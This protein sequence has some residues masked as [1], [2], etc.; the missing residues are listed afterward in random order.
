MK[1]LTHCLC[2]QLSSSSNEQYDL[3]IRQEVQ[4]VVIQFVLA[5]TWNNKMYITYLLI[6]MFMD[7]KE[8][9][10]PGRLGLI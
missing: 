6:S 4:V 2:T 1:H 8:I 5:L 9:T 10:P 7:N 3:L